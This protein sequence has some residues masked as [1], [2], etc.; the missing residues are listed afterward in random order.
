MP[1]NSPAL[2]LLHA[3]TAAEAVDLAL[4]HV[5]RPVWAPETNET[6]IRA[7]DL[8]AAVAALPSGACAFTATGRGSLD[9]FAARRDIYTCLRVID[10]QPTPYPGA[11]EFVVARPPFSVEAEEVVLKHHRATHLVVKNSGGNPARTKLTA[12]ANLGLPIVIVDR[13]PLPV[14]SMTV[15][16]EQAAFEWVKTQI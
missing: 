7:A 8:P 1:R 10:P 14:G 3:R 6:W 13:V 5:E 11:G 4:L 9:N 15:Q 12:A 2:V 16:D